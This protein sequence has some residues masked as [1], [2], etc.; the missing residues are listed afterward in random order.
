M[1][2]KVQAEQIKKQLID[3]LKNQN[4]PNKEAII[5]EIKSMN[6]KALEEFLIKNKLISSNSEKPEKQECVFCLI[7]Q[8]KLDSYI[9][10]ETKD[11]LAVLEINPLSKGHSIII[12]KK[13]LSIEKIPSSSF[14]LAKK[15]SKKIKAKLKP[16][17]IEISTASFMNHA[18][19]NIIPKYKD[20]KLEK[21]KAKEEDLIRLH[22]QLKIIPKPKIKKTEKIE[23]KS[24]QELKIPRRI[25]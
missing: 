22:E 16:E 21:I 19:I 18:A 14:T 2:E 11:N 20:K 25:P 13:H 23:K 6:E 4:I 15:I 24:E 5:N 3:G 8:K 9:L 10:D 12:P 17:E 1:L 7:S